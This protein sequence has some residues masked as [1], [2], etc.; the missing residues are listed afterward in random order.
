MFENEYIEVTIGKQKN[1]ALA[2]SSSDAV[3]GRKII[4]LSST[5]HPS[6]IR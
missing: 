4:G 5:W 1:I 3:A 2:N 6:K